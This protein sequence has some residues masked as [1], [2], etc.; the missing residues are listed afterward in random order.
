MKITSKNLV[1]DADVARASGGRGATHST[2]MASRNFLQAVLMICHKVVMTAA[3]QEEWNKHQSSFARK[4]RRSMVAK[5][6][7]VV[8]NAFEQLDIR[9]QIESLSISNNNKE[10]MLKDFHLIEAALASGCRVVSLDDEV[11]NLFSATINNLLD[12][13]AVLW[14]N[15][16]HDSVKVINWL[17]NGAPIGGRQY[18][19]WRLGH[20]E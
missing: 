19:K 12:L 6:K 10:A 13:R 5:R 4:W 18:Q 14:V 16:V 11:K 2:A 7:L 1:I 20:H 17:E 8:L 3:I 15:P 9:Q